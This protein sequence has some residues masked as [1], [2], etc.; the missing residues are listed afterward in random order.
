MQ[1]D[2]LDSLLIQRTLIKSIRDKAVS[3]KI[4]VIDTNTGYFLQ[5]AVMLLKPKRVLEIGCG[6]GFSTFFILKGMAGDAEYTGID[7]NRQRL[8]HAGKFISSRF[9]EAS[10]RFLCGNALKIIPLLEERYDLIFIDGAKHEY[11]LYLAALKGSLK[12]NTVLIAD[13]IFCRGNIF[14]DIYDGHFEN[15]IKGLMEYISLTDRQNGFDTSILDIDDGLAV[16]IYRGKGQI[17]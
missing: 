11:P 3:E 12:K 1:D 2:S 17:G 4:P 9:P 14:S 7:M 15:S 10:T 8:S 13:D 6:S 5:L 16:S